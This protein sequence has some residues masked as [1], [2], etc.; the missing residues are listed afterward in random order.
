MVKKQKSNLFGKENFS[1]WY[2]NLTS[3][4]KKLLF[5]FF[6]FLIL[7]LFINLTIETIRNYDNDL[8]LQE[9]NQLRS[10]D[11]RYVLGVQ[12]EN[13][14]LAFIYAFQFPFTLLL[15]AMALGWVIHGVG[16]HIIKR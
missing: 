5:T 7:V 1:R 8:S 13:K 16:F 3:L 10:D 14:V 4:D 6:G 2:K 12:E 15:I 9:C 11:V